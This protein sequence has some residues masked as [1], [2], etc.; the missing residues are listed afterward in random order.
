MRPLSVSCIKDF[1]YGSLLINGLE[2][3]KLGSLAGKH[4]KSVNGYKVLHC[5]LDNRVNVYV[6][7]NEP[8]PLFTPESKH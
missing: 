5:G 2:K 7:V 1:L 6:F 8:V 3:K 4:A